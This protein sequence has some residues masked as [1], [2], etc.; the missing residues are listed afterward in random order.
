MA[1]QTKRRLTWA[2]ALL[3]IG[4][5]AFT[6]VRA[7][8]NRADPA[9]LVD[10]RTVDQG[11]ITA[12]VTATGTLSALVTVEVGSQ[13][14]GR[15]Q[16]LHVDF[17]SPVKQGEVIARLDPQLLKASLDQARANY[18]SAEANLR[19]ARLQSEQA[20]RQVDRLRGLTERKMI[21]EA[22]LDTAQTTWE[23]AEA[24]ID[25]AAAALE[26]ARASL[27]LA[28]VNLE[29]ATITSPINGIVVSRN[30]DVGQTVAA[31]LQAPT[32]FVI[33]ED[34]RKMQVN[35]SVA[36][37]DVGKLEPGM[38]ATF[39][40]D[41]FPGEHF[42]GVVRQIRNAA[43]TVSNVV[44]Y[45]AVID[46]EN[47]DMKLRPGMT[48]NVTFVIEER[49]DVVRLPNAALRFRA[50]ADWQTPKDGAA[51]PA[52]PGQRRETDTIS[53]SAPGRGASNRRVVWVM[54]GGKPTSVPVV[55]GLSDGSLTELVEGDVKVGDEIVTGSPAAAGP[56]GG[57]S[58][59][60]RGP[61][62]GPGG[63]RL[64]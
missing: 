56:R 32:L 43:T 9:P 36:E 42:D 19:R 55:T 53:A 58:A 60:G 64:F 34:L 2:L 46:V 49:E 22:D 41:A 13:V 4:A 59:P 30:V 11:R 37:A 61:G 1:G 27:N 33:A 51:M 7:R 40:V 52:A 25:S 38:R 57:P 31:S 8:A 15:I 47:A 17:N 18:R 50:P 35:T 5:A 12:K 44:T 39:T 26:Q 16:E 6:F 20:K 45:D 62:R 48:A 54:R 63:I 28:R 10:T 3:V 14:S 23:T 21:A 29:Y 24:Q